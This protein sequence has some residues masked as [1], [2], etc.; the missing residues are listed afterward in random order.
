[1]LRGIGLFCLFLSASVLFG[2]GCTGSLGRPSGAVVY[3][4]N[5]GLSWQSRALLVGEKNRKTVLAAIEVSRMVTD[6]RNPKVLFMGTRGHGLFGSNNGGVTWSQFIP[7]EYITDIAFDAV[8]RCTL[9]VLT[10]RRALKTTSCAKEWSVILVESRASTAFMSIG[11]NP[12]SRNNVLVL[13]NTGDVFRSSD[14]GASWSAVYRFRERVMRNLVVDG[15]YASRAYAV[16]TDGYVYKASDWG[17]SWNDISGKMREKM[18]SPEFVGFS[19]LSRPGNLMYASRSSILV[20][21]NDGTSWEK[22]P[23]LTPNGTANIR[24]AS[25]DPR[26]ATSFVYATGS[27]LNLTSNSGQQWVVRPL[28]VDNDPS[29]ILVHPSKGSIYLGLRKIRDESQYW[30]R[31]Q[32]EFN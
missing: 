24:A 25:V 26:N 15:R 3:S 27:T 10:P 19:L 7:G 22:L 13:S 30:Y 12:R 29:V 9:Y 11:I 23:L 31:Q 32:G 4:D 21:R 20:T 14:G 18:S 28:P 2:A 8:D 17:V 5:Q 1:M 6:P 16:S